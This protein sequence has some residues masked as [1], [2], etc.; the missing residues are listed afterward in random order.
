MISVV[1]LSGRPVP[2]ALLRRAAGRTMG[3]RDV[4]IA[5]MDDAGMARL[6][7]RHLKRKGPTDVLA[8]PGEVAVGLDVAKREAKSRGLDWKEELARYA[9][10]GCLHLLGHDDHDPKRKT[11]MWRVQERIL[12]A[13]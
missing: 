4:T 6:H 10:H 5:V 2:T 7:Q 8:F 9:V 11:K 1:N 3:R 13:L 12:A